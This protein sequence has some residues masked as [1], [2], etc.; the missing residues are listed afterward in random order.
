MRFADRQESRRFL[1]KT[2]NF[3]AEQSRTTRNVCEERRHRKAAIQMNDADKYRIFLRKYGDTGKHLC[4]RD[5]EKKG[6]RKH[7]ECFGTK[8]NASPSKEGKALNR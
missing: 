3:K 5:G 6:I 4:V 1:E 7:F 2:Y 8:K